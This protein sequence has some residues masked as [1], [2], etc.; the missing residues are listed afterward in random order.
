MSVSHLKLWYWPLLSLFLWAS[1]SSIYLQES[2][3][4]GY[5][6]HSNS[7]HLSGI[8]CKLFTKIHKLH[9]QVHYS[10]D[11]FSGSIFYFAIV[12][13]D[14]TKYLRRGKGGQVYFTFLNLQFLW[15]GS[16]SSRNGSECGSRGRKLLA[17]IW[18]D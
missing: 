5:L 10:H 17:H 4:K 8:L 7:H 15:W 6:H 3:I 1:S 14:M 12:L 11:W 9:N 18:V 13:V 2:L 16:H